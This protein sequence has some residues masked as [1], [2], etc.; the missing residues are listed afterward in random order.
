MRKEGS[1]SDYNNSTD[2]CNTPSGI[3]YLLS[4][5]GA[6]ARCPPRTRI[7]PSSP[8]LGNVRGHHALNRQ[9]AVQ[10]IRKILLG[11]TRRETLGSHTL[12]MSRYQFYGI[13][14]LLWG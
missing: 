1:P 7:M 8:F 11:A 3:M 14:T 2:P 10:S 9:Q 6:G 13:G 4:A 5:C 12:P